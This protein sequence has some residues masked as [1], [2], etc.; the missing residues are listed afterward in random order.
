MNNNTKK[1]ILAII[2]LICGMALPAYD[3]FTGVA[4]CSSG[5]IMNELN[6]I[7]KLEA[8]VEM[9]ELNANYTEGE[10]DEN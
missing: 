2:W 5:F 10:K 4:W 1:F 8:K 9:K 6:R 7:N 3:L